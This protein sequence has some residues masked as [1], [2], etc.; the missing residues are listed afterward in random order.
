MRTVYKGVFEEPD[1]RLVSLLMRESSDWAGYAALGKWLQRTYRAR[2][3]RTLTVA[4]SFA[5]PNIASAEDYVTSR[6]GQLWEC[7]CESA[8]IVSN[9]VNVD[10]SSPRSAFRMFTKMLGKLNGWRQWRRTAVEDTL[11][12]QNLRLVRKV[13]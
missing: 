11:Y 8:R 13:T 7:R 1:G 2:D 5:F 12:C 6:H 4:H 3:G 9:I 10:S